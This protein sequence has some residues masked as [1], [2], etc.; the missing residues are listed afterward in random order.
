MLVSGRAEPGPRQPGL[1]P[2]TALSLRKQSPFPGTKGGSEQVP[3]NG[4]A[5]RLAG[6]V[7]R[8]EHVRANSVHISTLVTS[9]FWTSGFPEVPMARILVSN[10]RPLFFFFL[11]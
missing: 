8:E 4:L 7:E 9:R 2:T 5:Q 3:R 11:R 10:K 6:G 1:V